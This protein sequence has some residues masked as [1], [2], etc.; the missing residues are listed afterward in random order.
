[1]D[2]NI[3]QKIRELFIECM[4]SNKSLVAIPCDGNSYG[5][6]IGGNTHDIFTSIASL[7]KSVKDGDKSDPSKILL[8]DIILDAISINFTPSEISAEIDERV[9]KLI[10]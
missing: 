6:G 9:N 3:N 8:Y 4:K 2:E 10:P 1:M 7:F 5:I